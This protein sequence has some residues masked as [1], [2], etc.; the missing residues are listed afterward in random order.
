MWR[1][2]RVDIQVFGRWRLQLRRDHPC[3]QHVLPLQTRVRLTSVLV[4]W[5]AAGALTLFAAMQYARLEPE[6]SIWHNTE[7]DR[8]SHESQVGDVGKVPSATRSLGFTEPLY[9]AV[10]GNWT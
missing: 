1:L 3:W 2:T 10:T 7:S 4:R 6:L 9:R 5:F 8:L